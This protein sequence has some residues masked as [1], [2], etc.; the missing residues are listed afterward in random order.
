[1]SFPPAGRHRAVI[2]SFLSKRN[3]GLK[4][5]CLMDGAA[6]LA[7]SLGGL[8]A[9]QRQWL[10]PR[11]DKRQEREQRNSIKQSHSKRVKSNQSTWMILWNWWSEEKSMKQNMNWLGLIERE[12]KRKRGKHQQI[13]FNFSFSR[14]S[15]KKSEWIWLASFRFLFAS[16]SCLHFIHQQSKHFWIVDWIPLG[17]EKQTISL[18]LPPFIQENGVKGDWFFFL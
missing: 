2:Q 13:Q 10:R 18:S 7:L 14:W 5:G 17:K 12:T 11:K 16:S 8:W 3:V 15:E 6:L 9:H 4:A 1:M